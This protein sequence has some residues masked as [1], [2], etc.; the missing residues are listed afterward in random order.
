MYVNDSKGTTV[1]ATLAALDGSRRPVVLIA[2]GDGKGQ[3]FAP[4]QAGRR[5]ALPRRAADRPRRTSDRRALAGT[6]AAVERCGTLATAVA[7]AVALARPG[8][9][10]LLSPACA[11]LDQFA[12]YVERG[13]RVRARRSAPRIE[14]AAHA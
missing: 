5:R 3:D 14:A 1:V 6:P 10:V 11:S 8:D 13:E 2:G 4:L 9:A 12:T 7:R